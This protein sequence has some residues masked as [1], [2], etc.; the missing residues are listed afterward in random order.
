M[1]SPKV[2]LTDSFDGVQQIIHSLNGV[3]DCHVGGLIASLSDGLADDLV[4]DLTAGLPHGL[5]PCLLPVY[6]SYPSQGFLKIYLR[7]E[8]GEARMWTNQNE[9][10]F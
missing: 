5:A 4:A 7:G 10:R 1:Y 8:A 6:V 3:N 2:W 9:T